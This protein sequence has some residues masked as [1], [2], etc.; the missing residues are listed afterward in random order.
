MSSNRT[1][2]S[3]TSTLKMNSAVQ[4]SCLLL[5]LGCLLGSGHSQSEAEFAAKSREISQIFGNPSVDKYTKARNFPKLIAFYEKYSSRLHLTA[6]EKNNIDNSIKQYRAQQNH[7][8][9]GVSA[10]GGKLF[11]VLKKIIKVIVMVVDSTKANE[12]RQKT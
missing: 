7:Q 3:D 10:Q 5:V 11:D 1:V 2:H 12:E 4:I 9:D 8:V 6:Q